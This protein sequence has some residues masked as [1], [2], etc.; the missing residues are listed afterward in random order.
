[1]VMK[2]K[3]YKFA[4]LG[5][6][7][8]VIAAG[9]I[10]GIAINGNITNNDKSIKIG[11]TGPLTGPAA[12][13]GVDGIVAA[14]IAV[15]EINERGGV[16]GKMLELV[17]DDDQYVTA[18]TVTA[19]RKQVEVDGAD[20]LL[21]NTYSGIFAI[22][23]QAEKDGV[24]LIDSLDC[25]S[26][27]TALGDHVFC[28]ATESESIAT[29]MVEQAT[30]NGADT[31]GILYYNSDEFMPLVKDVFIENFNGN[32]LAEAHSMGEKDFRTSIFKML[33]GN[34]DALVLLGYDETGIAMRQARELG[35]EGDFY[36]TGTITSPGLQEAA[37]GHADGTY[38]SF[39]TI[40]KNTGVGKDFT[41][42]FI[43]IQGRP[44]IEDFATYP[45][46]DAVYVIAHAIEKAGSTDKDSLIKEI[47]NI[48]GLKGISGE[49]SFD[50]N[51]GMKIPE[52]AHIL[53]D[54]KVVP[55]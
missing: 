14:Q 23:E 30:K 44:P 16:N 4:A 47:L 35:F 12:I 49:I 15:D 38:V 48:Q 33:N 32:I 27:I 13:L 34:I 17:V 19:Y 1:M 51:G 8:L 40:P 9:I 29:T 20:I 7:V 42:K 26:R 46:Y 45:T 52:S 31:V 3:N 6:V 36:S 5:I 25:N 2:M 37:G 41:D 28:L 53:K 55:L 10:S 18:L 43:E 11:W 24:I 50:G 39:W 21:V 22:A 54:G